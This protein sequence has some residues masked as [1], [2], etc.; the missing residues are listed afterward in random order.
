VNGAI[1]GSWLDGRGQ[2]IKAETV[3]GAIHFQMAGLKGRL[4][5]GNVNGHLSFNA[6]GAEQ[7]TVNKNSVTASF[8]GSN[9]GIDLETVNGSITMD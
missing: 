1:T 5:A 6:K 2:G 9:Q 3:N 8:P 4:K 7:I